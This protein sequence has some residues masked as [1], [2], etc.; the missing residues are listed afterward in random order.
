MTRENKRSYEWNST[1]LEMISSSAYMTVDEGDE[2]RDYR[3][4]AHG[5]ARDA[6]LA[7]SIAFPTA[8]DGLGLVS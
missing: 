7:V 4:S 8:C 6:C 5:A 1:R 3:V 2:R